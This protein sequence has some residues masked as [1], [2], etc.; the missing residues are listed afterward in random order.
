[1]ETYHEPTK[2]SIMATSDSRLGYVVE[3]F[4]FIISVMAI[5]SKHEVNVPEIRSA[6][7]FTRSRP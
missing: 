7:I 6:G 4:Y 1:M 2:L 3:G 5:N